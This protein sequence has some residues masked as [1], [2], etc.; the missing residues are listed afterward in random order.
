VVAAGLGFVTSRE[1]DNKA[2]LV[3]SLAILA[4]GTYGAVATGKYFERWLRHWRRADAYQA[5]LFELY[6]E[7]DEHL[8]AYSA[9]A[10]QKRTDPYEKEIEER[11][12]R[13]SRVKLYRLWITFHCAIALAGAIMTLVFVVLILT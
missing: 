9:T 5:Q 3:V 8:R 2:A 7:I 4:L 10:L 13:L 11:F 12:P 1:D 6:P